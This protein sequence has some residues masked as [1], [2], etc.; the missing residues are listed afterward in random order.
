VMLPSQKKQDDQVIK[1]YW[2]RSFVSACLA[3]LSFIFLM[4]FLGFFA[5]SGSLWLF[6]MLVTVPFVYGFTFLAGLPIHLCLV[7][8]G[9]E[10]LRHYVL[11][12]LVF[13]SLAVFVAFYYERLS[14]LPVDWWFT[15]S[16]FAY[17]AGGLAIAISGWFLYYRF[18]VSIRR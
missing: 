10:K 2:W 17:A 18:F 1:I 13:S 8:T 9:N 5:R 12:Y 14:G 6:I 4:A 11:S 3:P 15:M 16:L 7:R